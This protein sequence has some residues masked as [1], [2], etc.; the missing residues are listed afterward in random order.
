MDAMFVSIHNFNNLCIK[1]N[2]KS[3]GIGLCLLIK[4]IIDFGKPMDK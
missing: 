3:M 1:L 4:I 2:D